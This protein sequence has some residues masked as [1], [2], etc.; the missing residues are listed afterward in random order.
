MKIV[1]IL[2]FLLILSLSAFSQAPRPLAQTL[3]S[4]GDPTPD[5]QYL[6]EMINRARANPA[7][8]GLR[9][10][11]TTD[12]Q[13]LAS[14]SYWGV[15][16]DGL[17]AIFATYPSRPPLA[18]NAKLIAAAR[19]HTAD[20]IA[21][22]FQG[23][24]G[25]DG[26]SMDQRI[27]RELYTG[28]TG[29]GE[30]VSAYS[31][32]LWYAHCGFIVDW[33]VA[34]LGHR[35]NVLNFETTVYKEAGFGLTYESNP[36]T[37]V[38]PIVVTEDFGVIPK[39]AFLCGVAYVDRN[40]NNF[41]D[42][43]EGLS[44][45]T[46][47]PKAGNYYSITS[48]SGGYAIPC[49]GVSGQV[50]VTAS[51]GPLGSTVITRMVTLNGTD[52]VKLD[53]T[54]N[55]PPV[56]VTGLQPA[57]GLEISSP[58]VSVSWTAG[59]GVTK[60]WIQV[61]TDSNFTT[62]LFSDSTLTTPSA[63]L[64]SLPH[65]TRIFWRVVARNDVGWGQPSASAWLTVNLIPGTCQLD[66]PVHQAEMDV[67]TV[68]FGWFRPSSATTR[69]W[70]EVS[71][72][73][74]FTAL[75][76]RDSTLSD[77]TLSLNLANGSTYFW[78]VK[79]GSP[80]G[81]GPFS[82]VRTL[83]VKIL[84]M[85]P[86]TF[87]QMFVCNPV[88]LWWTGTTPEVL[89]YHV[90]VYKDGPSQ[91]LLVSDTAVADT[92]TTVSAPPAV[93]TLWFRVRAWNRAGYGAWSEFSSVSTI[94]HGVPDT[95]ELS[96]PVSRTE[97]CCDS[98]EL[99]WMR[100]DMLEFD[101]EVYNQSSGTLF[102]SQHLTGTSQKISGLLKGAAYAWRVRGYNPCGAG[103]W[104]DMW[105]FTVSTVSTP[106]V[107]HPMDFRVG[108]PSPNPGIT[109]VTV[110]IYHATAPV[111]MELRSEDGRLVLTRTESLAQPTGWIRVPVHHLTSGTYFLFLRS[112]Q[113]LTMRKI[114]VLR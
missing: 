105:S 97:V 2:T 35:K 58:S 32:S 72:N 93:G 41:Y 39:T 51:G 18:F 29:I 1:S 20:M 84:P 3:Y 44:G 13:V 45:V 57:S 109:E 62:L 107:P 21:H 67:A 66:Y 6:L 50:E 78:R 26:S 47:T 63:L 77:T 55:V 70:I 65:G 92:S 75:V 42:V 98:V 25:S 54:G 96:T 15:N 4:H 87:G 85:R 43:G 28:W 53:F 14:Y 94:F 23:H 113:N 79:A 81:W 11:T 82:E 49:F 100:K 10:A 34:S 101:V 56:P 76:R 112:G 83:R 36:S 110:P 68:S 30:N 89:R 27:D 69:Y 52:N 91:G 5:E 12:A 111:E 88:V 22:D 71:T 16:K 103:P 8:E 19:K 104:S 24:T 108:E 74:Q 37:Q 106:K 48:T 102:F 86:T 31:K 40:K 95:T 64:S 114:L 7:E 33:G 99:R 80:Y 73:S 90:E 46:I 61:S 59:E 17:P 60:Y 38:G 9:L